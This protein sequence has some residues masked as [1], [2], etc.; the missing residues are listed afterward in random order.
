MGKIIWGVGASVSASGNR[1]PDEGKSSGSGVR[2]GSED[3]GRSLSSV[4]VRNQATT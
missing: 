1:S 4:C 2:Q 3:V